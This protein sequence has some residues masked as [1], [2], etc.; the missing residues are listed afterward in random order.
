MS[1]Q[2]RCGSSY[3]LGKECHCTV[4][5]KEFQ[6]GE[7]CCG[8]RAAVKISAVPVSSDEELTAKGLA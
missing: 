3:G 8:V 7:V 2:Q 5:V 6:V 1:E 4:G